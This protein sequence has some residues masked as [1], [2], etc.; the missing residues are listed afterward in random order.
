M[1]HRPATENDLRLTHRPIGVFDSG[2]GGLAVLAALSRRFPGKDFIYYGDHA[3]A[4]Y[5]VRTA[6]EIEDLLRRAAGHL[7][8]RGCGIVIVACNTASLLALR[9]LQTTW[10]PDAYPD[11]RLLGVSVPVVE[12][13]TGRPWHAEDD[14]R[15]FAPRSEIAVFATPA[16]VQS[17]LF[18]RFITDRLPNTRVHEHPC[19]TLARLIEEGAPAPAIQAAVADEVATLMGQGGSPDTAVLGCTH[20]ALIRH[21]FEQALPQGLRILDQPSIVAQKL[22]AYLD[23]RGGLRQTASDDR[24]SLWTTGV[25]D[26][27]AH[28]AAAMAK[29]APQLRQT[30]PLHAWGAI[31][32]D[33]R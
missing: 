5:G 29:A 18:G 7:F 24:L 22:E 8:T 3:H 16:T 9:T 15:D 20:Y 32:G 31:R 6:A 2:L 14:H 19:P 13:I 10:L 26:R 27:V 11:R 30:L 23:R 17:G 12:E 21:A 1:T 28:A 25:P 4:P 33:S